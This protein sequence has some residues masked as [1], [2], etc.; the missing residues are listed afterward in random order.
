[1]AGRLGLAAARF[2]DRTRAREAVANVNEA[3]DYAK[4]AGE[5]REFKRAST[6][7]KDDN[8]ASLQYQDFL[9]LGKSFLCAEQ[10]A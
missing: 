8:A 7:A 6:E 5:L 1:V 3:P 2:S 9:T 4:E 10:L